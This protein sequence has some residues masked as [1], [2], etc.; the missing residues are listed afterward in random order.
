MA[1]LKKI[2]KKVVKPAYKKV[3]KPAIKE[4]YKATGWSSRPRKE[5]AQRD[6]EKKHGKRNKG[7]RY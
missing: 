4:A 3:I 6:W 1:I 7:R 5:K 2:Y